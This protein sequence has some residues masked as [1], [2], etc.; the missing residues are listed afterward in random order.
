MIGNADWKFDPEDLEM[1]ITTLSCKEFTFSHPEGSVS[2]EL[3]P[4]ANEA[5]ATQ[6]LELINLNSNSDNYG[7][8]IVDK[9]D[10]ARIIELSQEFNIPFKQLN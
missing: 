8:V 7:F 4:Y 1:F 6:N 3:F 2:H 9:D 5:L 10:V